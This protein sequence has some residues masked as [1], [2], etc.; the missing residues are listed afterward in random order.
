MVSAPQE[1]MPIASRL[2]SRTGYDHRQVQGQLR[3][4]A[5]VVQQPTPLWVNRDGFAMSVA[6]PVSAQFRT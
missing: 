3:V 2:K 1:M 4:A 5:T 6:S